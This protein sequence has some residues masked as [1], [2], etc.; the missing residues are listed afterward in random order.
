MLELIRFII[1]RLIKAANGI[2]SGSAPLTLIEPNLRLSFHPLSLYLSHLD[3]DVGQAETKELPQP[4]S[5]PDAPPPSPSI[6][7]LHHQPQHRQ[8]FIAGGHDSQTAACLCLCVCRAAEPLCDLTE[9]DSSLLFDLDKAE[10]AR[11]SQITLLFS[12]L[13]TTFFFRTSKFFTQ[14]RSLE[15]VLLLFLKTTN[16]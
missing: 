5:G 12:N 13:D 8:P 9:T 14:L 3:T 10:Q 16:L 2:S 11:R 7:C 15:N 6:L 1:T 4:A